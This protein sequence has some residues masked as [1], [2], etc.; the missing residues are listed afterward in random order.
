[1]QYQIVTI[2]AYRGIGLKWEGA[3]SEVDELKKMIASMQGRV[4]ELEHALH[5]ELQL[6]LSYHLRPDGFVHYSVYEVDEKQQVPEGM[7]EINV[8]EMTYFTTHHAKGESIGGTYSKIHQ[9]MDENDY[10]PYGEAEVEYFDSLP[11]KHERY[12]HDRDVD[13]P[14]FDIRIPIVKK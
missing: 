7:I 11:I 2:P 1:M 3:Y 6:G 12:P 14:H 13:D 9:W 10:H 4:S 8:P 5:P